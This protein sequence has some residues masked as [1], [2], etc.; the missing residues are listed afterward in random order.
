MCPHLFHCVATMYFDRNLADSHILGDLLIHKT[1]GHELHDLLLASRQR[2]V[3]PP[4]DGDRTCGFTS[5]AIKLKGGLYRLEDILVAKRFSQEFDS[6]V[7]HGPDGHRYVAVAS[8]KNDRDFDTDLGQFNLKLKSAHP[9]QSNVKDET[10]GDVWARRIEEFRSLRERIDAQ[11]DTPKQGLS[12]SRTEASSSTT[13]TTCCSAVSIVIRTLRYQ[14]DDRSSLIKVNT[15]S[16]DRT[17]PIFGVVDAWRSQ[18]HRG[19]L[20]GHQRP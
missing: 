8:D 15:R 14:C 1:S 3:I 20:E 7:S 2:V 11:S 4:Q 5:T 9:R 16:N 6:A 19:E 13:K 12:D 10:P 18:H 17:W